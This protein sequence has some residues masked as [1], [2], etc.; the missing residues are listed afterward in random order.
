ML[1]AS[2]LTPKQPENESWR[3]SRPASPHIPGTNTVPQSWFTV[4]AA[5]RAR[6]CGVSAPVD[7]ILSS[8]PVIK[9]EFPLASVRTGVTAFLFCESDVGDYTLPAFY[10]C[11]PL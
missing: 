7:E 3:N 11:V 8:K 9:A 2:V 4:E 6:G 1:T 5:R 10:V